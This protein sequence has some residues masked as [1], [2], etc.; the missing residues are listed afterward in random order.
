MSDPDALHA[1]ALDLLVQ[2]DTAGA[3]SDLKGYLAIE[4]EDDE[5]WF[6][7][8]SAYASIQHWIQAA[9]ALRASIDLDGAVPEVRLAYAPITEPLVAMT[10]DDGL[11]RARLALISVLAVSTDIGDLLR[12]ARAAQVLATLP[13]TP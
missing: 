1:K 8:G 13:A 11:R 9:D 6:E 10:L 7:L 4:P 3:I 2:G 12:A 5:A